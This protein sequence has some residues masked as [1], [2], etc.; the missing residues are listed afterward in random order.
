MS[1]PF[2]VSD[3]IERSVLTGNRIRLKRVGVISLGLFF[4]A[5]AFVTSAVVCF[6]V[7]VVVIA[8]LM[9]ERWPAADILALFF[10]PIIYAIVG[11]IAGVFYATVYNV[12]AAMTGGIELEI[13]SK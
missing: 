3:G 12:I 10:M 2:A 4:A 1:N 7:L 8:G 11:F 13:E 6:L 9:N 5:G